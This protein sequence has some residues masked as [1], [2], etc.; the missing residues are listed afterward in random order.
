MK[1]GYLRVWGKC[2]ED[3][4]IKFKKEDEKWLPRSWGSRGE[5]R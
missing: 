2:G 5:D 3:Q 1:N 4:Q